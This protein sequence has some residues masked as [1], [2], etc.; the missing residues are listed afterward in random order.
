MKRI[1]AF[2]T[3][4]IPLLHADG[5]A[6]KQHVCEVLPT[7]D[8]WC[9]EERAKYLID[10]FLET[11]PKLCV[12]IG[13]YAGRT[14]F[15]VAS[16]LKFLDDGVAI[17]IDPWDKYEMLK[18]FDPV[19]DSTNL[20]AWGNV[21][22]ENVYRTFLNLLKRFELENYCIILR[23]KSSEA[24][25]MISSEIDFLCLDG[26]PSEMCSTQDVELYLPMV[27]PGGYVLL[28]DILQPAK[29]KAAELLLKECEVVKR[30]DHGNCV[31]FKKTRVH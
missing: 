15:P 9:T 16:S 13:V 28:Y 27:R 17:G 29:I 21:D 4:F 7:I 6:L 31:L 11:K 19:K 1:I 18:S 30:F 5:T 8:G 3:F 26:N 22:F 20:R 12:E 10:L 23:M 25:S 24:A 14:F 2:F